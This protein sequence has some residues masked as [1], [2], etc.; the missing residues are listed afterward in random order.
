MQNTVTL[1]I[2][3]EEYLTVIMNE[4]FLDDVFQ[5]ARRTQFSV[6]ALVRGPTPTDR[7]SAAP[8]S[9]AAISMANTSSGS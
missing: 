6:I 8:T 5:E 1:R 4:S 2:D 7:Q 9:S 3:E